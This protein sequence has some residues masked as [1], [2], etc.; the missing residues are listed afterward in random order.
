MAGAAMSDDAPTLLCDLCSAPAM[1]IEPGS[2][3]ATALD[4]FRISRPE[5]QRQWCAAHW[6]ASWRRSP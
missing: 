1:A 5:P 2:E 4:L 6:P 3:A